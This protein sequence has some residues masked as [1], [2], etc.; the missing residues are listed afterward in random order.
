MASAGVKLG[1]NT[2]SEILSEFINTSVSIQEIAERYDVA[3]NTV[4]RLCKGLDR[5]GVP[6]PNMYAQIAARCQHLPETTETDD[7]DETDGDTKATIAWFQ[8]AGMKVAI[9]AMQNVDE[10]FISPSELK[11]ITEV[12]L[13]CM[14]ITGAAPYYR[15][16]P[17]IAPIMPDAPVPTLDD[18][19]KNMP[20]AGSGVSSGSI[21]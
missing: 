17:L 8:N 6:S 15:E 2:K 9:R 7:T 18:F 3:P 11:K 16:P 4:I 12:L 14:R 5:L 20:V 19:Y 10:P 21:T 1:P 13:N